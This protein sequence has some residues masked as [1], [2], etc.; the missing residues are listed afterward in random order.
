[1]AVG[2]SHALAALFLEHPDLWSACFAFD[3]GQDACVGDEGGAG[4]H[5][6]AVLLD[7]QHVLE[8]QLRA[9]LTCGSVNRGE[10]AR[11]DLE[12]TSGRLDDCVHYRPLC[13]GDSLQPK[14]LILQTL[15]VSAD[16]TP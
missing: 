5:F 10:P 7:E 1:M 2:P 8:R 9:G 14:W 11:G 12:L 13:K 6:A 4:E 3:D 15:S 16:P